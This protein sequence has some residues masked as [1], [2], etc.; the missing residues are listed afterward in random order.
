[1]IGCDELSP[2][3]ISVENCA[4]KLSPEKEAEIHK[5]M[6]FGLTQETVTFVLSNS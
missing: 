5:E 3:D 2:V 4:S 1:M 6:P